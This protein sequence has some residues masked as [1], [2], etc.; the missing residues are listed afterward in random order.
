[1]HDKADALK[2]DG[3]TLTINYPSFLKYHHCDVTK[4]IDDYPSKSKEKSE[5]N[6]SV[7]RASRERQEKNRTDKIDK[8]DKIDRQSAHARVDSADANKNKNS[9]QVHDNPYDDER[10]TRE[11]MQAWTI[12]WPILGMAK[13]RHPEAKWAVDEM[14][15]AGLIV[16][17]LVDIVKRSG[18]KK[19]LEDASWR[20]QQAIERTDLT[21]I[22]DPAQHFWSLDNYRKRDKEWID[23][24]P[25]CADCGKPAPYQWQ[26]TPL[27]SKHHKTRDSAHARRKRKNGKGL[28]SASDLVDSN[29]KE[30]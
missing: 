4:D 19:T 9:E 27:C 30:Q 23:S 16:D 26:Q 12:A 11:E 29:K 5:P 14:Q 7:K 20:L 28:Q 15:D 22:A 3:N 24:L 10:C 2:I 8:I 25:A 21:D 1:M 13:Q 18:G 17:A 6:E